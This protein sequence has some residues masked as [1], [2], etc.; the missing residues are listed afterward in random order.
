MS[1]VVAEFEIK[2]KNINRS[3]FLKILNYAKEHYK[4]DNFEMDL[5]IIENKSHISSI[6]RRTFYNNK[7]VKIN[8]MPIIINK[9]SI[10]KKHINNIYDV[11]LT[12]SH[13]TEIPI[14]K[15]VFGNNLLIRLKKRLSFKLNNDYRLDLTVIKNESSI[16]NLDVII[17]K[18]FK[19]FNES[20]FSN[21]DLF[22]DAYEIEIEFIGNRHMEIQILENETK[23]LMEAINIYQNPIN[24]IYALMTDNHKRYNI[25]LR[26][27]LNSAKQLNKFVY[28]KEVYP[29]NGYVLLEK[30][31]GLRT[32]CAILNNVLYLL[33]TQSDKNFYYKLS[34]KIFDNLNFILDCE[35]I[36]GKI[37]VFDI[38][39]VNNKKVWKEN[40][41]TRLSF[42]NEVKDII[43][44]INKKILNIEFKKYNI[45]NNNFRQLIETYYLENKGDK[46]IDGLIIAEADKNYFDTTNYKWKPFEHNT[47]D[48]YAKLVSSTSQKEGCIYNLYSYITYDKLE[49]LCVNKSDLQR[50]EHHPNLTNILFSPSI[51][52]KAYIFKYKDNSLNGKVIELGKDKKTFEWVFHKIRDDKIFGNNFQTAEMTYYNF[53]SPFELEML[54]TIDEDPYF[55]NQNE[56]HDNFSHIRTFN[57][58]IKYELYK[59][60]NKSEFILDLAAGRGADLNKY[61]QN[62]IQNVLMVEVDETAI[63]TILERKYSSIK[64]KSNYKQAQIH[65]TKIYILKEDLTNNYVEIYDKIINIVNKKT[66]NHICSHFA[67]HYFI[68]NNELMTNFINLLNLT[69]DKNGIFICTLVDGEKLKKYLLKLPNYEWK[70][71]K[72]YIKLLANKKEIELILP[73]SNNE[74]YKEYIINI[75]DFI[76]QMKN[77]NFKLIEKKNFL[78]YTNISQ[79]NLDDNDKTFVD[80]YCSVIFTKK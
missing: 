59:M 34:N 60:F 18:F 13:S 16:N 52:P 65:N 24:E 56:K 20:N 46:K 40:Y 5:N 12:L 28:Y 49:K 44:L 63:Y 10:K 32:V 7:A 66:F 33:F 58:A 23:H 2:L 31:D 22:I 3:T 55:I 8:K 62:N 70:N 4:I 53:Y 80:F 30:T 73:F 68:Y 15:Y 79:Q 78:E 67:M 54:Y 71:D 41:V 75:D 39:Y 27:I 69:L 14:E 6:R 74:L 64:Q 45:I 36:E 17:H 37:M 35:F 48:F 42:T 72:Y 47:I 51:D 57:S 43:K 25:E 76:L 1:S 29:A 77:N 19:D 26:N 38:M 9:N 21:N 50:I 11:D 61:F